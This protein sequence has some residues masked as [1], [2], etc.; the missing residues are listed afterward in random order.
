MN[1][2]KVSRS[3]SPIAV[4]VITLLFIHP[5]I[6]VA[7]CDECVSNKITLFDAT[8]DATEP[9][10]TDTIAYTRWLDLHSIGSFA[11]TIS[12]DEDPTKSC[13]IWVDMGTYLSGSSSSWVYGMENITPPPSGSIKSTDYLLTGS[14]VT[15]K[16]DSL[17]MFSWW[18]ECGTSREVVKG[19]S[20]VYAITSG[21][22][23][24]VTAARQA[25]QGLQPL[26]QTIQNFEID[27]R[28]QDMKVARDDESDIIMTP[29]KTNLQL[30]DSTRIELKLVD[31]CDDYPLQGRE[32]ILEDYTDPELG[33]VCSS[34]RGGTVSPTRVTTDGDGKAWVTFTSGS[35]PGVGRV[36]AAYI[37]KKPHGLPFCITGSTR[38]NLPSNMYDVSCKWYQDDYSSSDV[39]SSEG[40]PTIRNTANAFFHAQGRFSFLYENKNPDNHGEDTLIVNA[41]D[42]S[43]AGTVESMVFFGSS[44][45]MSV[46]RMETFDEDGNIVGY[47]RANSMATGIT[48]DESHPGLFFQKSGTYGFVQFGA[49]QHRIGHAHITLTGS[50][51]GGAVAIDEWSILANIFFS[52]FD[53]GANFRSLDN[54]FEA[55][56]FCNNITSGGGHSSTNKI[57]LEATFIN[58]NPTTGIENSSSQALPKRIVLYQNYPNP[59]N[60]STSISFSLP[61]KIFVSLD[62]FDIL[63]RKVATIVSEQMPAGNYVQYWNA[64]G[65]PSGVY[66]YRLKAG[67][68]TETK[69]LLLLK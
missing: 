7:Q 27:K 59:F 34:P 31:K 2:S 52:S 55:K 23:G 56:Y 24:R 22:T 3:A 50:P 25:V 29:D 28:A 4:I 19:S 69:K 68:Y 63:G 46:T 44:Q 16:S 38:F 40:G 58:Q 54:S 49:S 8:V 66:F 64:S 33:Y 10:S 51:D 43:S 57:R 13:F 67:A 37:C 14:V 18:L 21:Q 65:F 26:L 35:T 6:A 41:P 45:E 32:I 39:T 5:A 62:I 15:L 12:Q 48:G 9:L 61:R 47:Y 42:D 53:P 1:T 30:N 17:Y 11:R 20:S 36:S 60:P